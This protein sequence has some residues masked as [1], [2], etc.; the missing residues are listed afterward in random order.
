MTKNCSSQS[1][2]V[3]RSWVGIAYDGGSE[4]LGLSKSVQC[5]ISAIARRDSRIPSSP[6]IA[7]L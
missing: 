5:P 4:D 2:E 6:I 7:T 1:R 3:S